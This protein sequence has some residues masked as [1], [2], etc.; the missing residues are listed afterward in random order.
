[1]LP[2]RIVRYGSCQIS[3]EGIELRRC[4]QIYRLRKII[5]G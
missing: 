2:C 3:K 4:H 1:M 5:V